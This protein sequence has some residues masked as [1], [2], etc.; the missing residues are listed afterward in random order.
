MSVYERRMSGWVRT[1]PRSDAKRVRHH[2]GT[3]ERGPPVMTLADLIAA[4][5]G[6]LSYEALAQRGG[7]STAAVHKFA[8]GN[9]K[10]FPPPATV[11]GLARA[12]QVPVRDVV[13]AAAYGLG[14]DMRED[15]GTT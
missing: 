12:L 15:T 13:M 8:T 5:K 3:T 14:L 9:N 4:R 7:L 6:D 2:R 10:D 11:H 1:I